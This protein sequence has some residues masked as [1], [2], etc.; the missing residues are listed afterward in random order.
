MCTCDDA[1]DRLEESPA[2]SNP[3]DR[4]HVAGINRLLTHITIKAHFSTNIQHFGDSMKAGIRQVSHPGCPDTRR[5]NQW[6][7]QQV[8][9]KSNHLGRV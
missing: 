3:G 4:E 5:N 7:E 1:D 8:Q 2:K 6:R 9:R